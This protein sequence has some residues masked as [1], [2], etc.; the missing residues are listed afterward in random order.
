MGLIKRIGNEEIKYY[1]KF[2][3]YS[4]IRLIFLGNFMVYC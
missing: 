1:V 3:I 4:C 2:Y